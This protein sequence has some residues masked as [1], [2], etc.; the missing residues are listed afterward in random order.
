MKVSNNPKPGGNHD[1]V[2]RETLN[3][4]QRKDA[5]MH[6]DEPSPDPRDDINK[7]HLPKGHEALKNRKGKEQAESSESKPTK[8]FGNLDKLT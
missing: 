6:K 2:S 4:W 8:P 5:K 7:P 3:D 1:G